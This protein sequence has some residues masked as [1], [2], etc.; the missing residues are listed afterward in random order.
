MIESLR[1][2]ESHYNIRVRQFSGLSYTLDL[3]KL[4]KLISTVQIANKLGSCELDDFGRHKT[5]KASD[6]LD[7][8]TE[9]DQS[10]SVIVGQDIL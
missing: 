1:A 10:A 5:S 9:F 4:T 6:W 2:R 8:V 7:C 3:A